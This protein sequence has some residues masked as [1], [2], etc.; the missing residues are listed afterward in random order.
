MRIAVILINVLRMVHMCGLIHGNV[1]PDNIM[2]DTHTK[3]AKAYLIDYAFSYSYLD[4][5]GD[6]IPRRHATSFVGSPKYC[7]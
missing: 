6:H 1:K 3:L 2:M 5:R 7:S 4:E